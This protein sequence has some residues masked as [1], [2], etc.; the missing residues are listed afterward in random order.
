[1]TSDIIHTRNQGLWLELEASIRRGARLC[2]HSGQVGPGDVFVALPGLSHDGSVHIPKAVQQ[3]AAWVVHPS[4]VH[5][6]CSQ[7]GVRFVS[8]SNIHAALGRLAGIMYGTDQARP[9][10]VGVTGTNGK[11]TVTY[12]LEHI[13]KAAG[14]RTGVL[15]TIS[16]RWPGQEQEAALTTPGC[17]DLHAM[18]AK[19]AQAGVEV[20]CMEVSSHALSQHR[21]AGLE[22]DLAVFTNLSQ[23]HL[24]YHQDMDSYFQVK[25]GLFQGPRVRSVLNIDD[26]YGRE[27]LAVGRPGRCFTTCGRSVRGW[28]CVQGKVEAMSRQGQ[29]L[30]L[31]QEEQTWGLRC[32]LVGRHNASNLMAAQA[33]GLELGLDHRAFASLQSLNGPPGRLQRIEN[34][35]GL[36]VFVDYAHTPDAL[37]NVLT[38]VADLDFERIIVVFGC[39][40]DRDPGK[41]PLMGQAV[42]RHAHLAVLTSDNPRHEDPEAIMDAVMPGLQGGVQV[43]REV[44]R[45]RAIALALQEMGPLDALII[46]G[47]G[48]EGTQQIGDRKVLLKDAQVVREWFGQ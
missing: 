48:H 37:D 22:F 44:N 16:Y 5:P 20:A 18:L 47:K 40:G 41:R 3:G 34:S 9:L 25:A 24:D 32:S 14:K 45:R 35:Q 28:P 42:A 23:D 31:R 36:H 17:L 19:M 30:C 7:P 46:A 21:L 4:G 2:T 33:A 26:A 10:L 8:V 15:G 12:M 29:V 13:L 39:G 1:M 43:I 27:L 38:A 11:T 6:Q